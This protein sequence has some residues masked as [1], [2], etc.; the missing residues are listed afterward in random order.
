[1]QSPQEYIRSYVRVLVSHPEKVNVRI[2]E[3]PIRIDIQVSAEDLAEITAQ[4]RES[5]V[6]LCRTMGLKRSAFDLKVS[7]V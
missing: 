1:M 5:I 4:N 6:A 2:R 7:G 3:D